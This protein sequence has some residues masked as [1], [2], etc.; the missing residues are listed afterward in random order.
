[1]INLFRILAVAAL[2]GGCAQVERTA[3]PAPDAD[4]AENVAPPEPEDTAETRTDQAPATGD[5]GLTIASLGSAREPGTWMKTPL[6]TAPGRGR[7]SDP[8]TGQSVD[9]DLIPLDAAPGSGSQLSVA[10]FQALGASLTGLP[11][12]RV[13]GLGE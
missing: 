7:V 5:L 3:Q 2:L 10:G 1:M 6:V 4:P 8:R 9:V 12:L 13:M 11:E